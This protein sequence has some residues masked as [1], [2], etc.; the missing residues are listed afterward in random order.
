MTTFAEG[1]ICDR[2]KLQLPDFRI[3]FHAA[4]P[5]WEIGRL[6]HMAERVEPGMVVCDVGAEMGDFTSLYRSWG[7][8]V[9]PVEPMPAMW[10]S[11]R[12]TWEANGY[13]PP[14][15]C[16]AGFAA[17][18]STRL[19]DGLH[20]GDWPRATD[21]PVVADPGF[22]HLAQ[23]AHI[24]PCVTIDD[25]AELVPPPDVLML[26]VEGAEWHVLDGARRVLREGSLLVYASV[27]PPTMKNWYRRTPVDL[28]RLMKECG[29][30]GTRLPHHGEGEE[31]W[32]YERAT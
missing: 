4:R 24:E 6:E 8:A 22:R 14:P 3:D 15:A 27:H 12:A 19:L 18:R 21:G 23:Q 28:W 30:D 25:L 13:D 9:I 26:D 16:F 20:L 7:A 5:K 29:Y 10:P 2:W 11:I 32:F 1:I 17:D 31:F